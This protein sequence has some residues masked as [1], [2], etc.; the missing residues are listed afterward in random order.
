MDREQ[1]SES[2]ILNGMEQEIEQ[3]KQ[4]KD[5]A[6]TKA[7]WRSI[8]IVA[9][10][11]VVLGGIFAGVGIYAEKK[12]QEGQQVDY[13]KQAKSG[14]A[15]FVSED[16]EPDASATEITALITEL[17]YT[18]DD[19]MAVN[20]CFA[21]GMGKDQRLNSVD[22]SI[23]NADGEVIAAGFSDA[24]DD[25]YF[26]PTGGT[27]TLILYISPEYVQIKDD[28]LATISYEVTMN[29]DPV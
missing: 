16:T 6:A 28:S 19:S 27:A 5:K 26:I 4:V 22:V 11:I 1:F 7:M 21:N 9:L 10:V 18:N 14:V 29:Y 12:F 15:A 2:S 23:R 20:L 17:Y 13:E 8:G 3:P 24:I 25:N